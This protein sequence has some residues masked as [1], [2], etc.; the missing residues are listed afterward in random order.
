MISFDAY[1]ES[2]SED[3]GVILTVTHDQ[4]KENAFLVALDGRTFKEIARAKMPWHIPSSFHGQYFLESS[5][6]SMQSALSD[7]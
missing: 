2:Q 6:H 5:F 1:P 4:N 3:D 7:R